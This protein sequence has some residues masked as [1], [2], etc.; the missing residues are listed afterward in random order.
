VRS[1]DLA[2]HGT[3]ADDDARFRSSMRR[4][5]SRARS[6][7]DDDFTYV[8]AGKSEIQ[9]KHIYMLLLDMSMFL[10]ARVSKFVLLLLS[11][12]F[13]NVGRWW[14][15]VVSRRRCRLLIVIVF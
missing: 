4:L 3:A 1:Q 5:Y 13:D 11:S 8:V 14:C 10:S 7:T 6:K 12:A 9:K 2:R 15:V